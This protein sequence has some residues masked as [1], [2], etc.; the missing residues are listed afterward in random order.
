MES[1]IYS[2]IDS[3]NVISAQKNFLE[4]RASLLRSLQYLTNYKVIRKKE[5]LM[6]IKL[7]KLVKEANTEI[8]KLLKQVPKTENI[9]E[10]EIEYRNIRNKRAKIK[11]PIHANIEA[12][13]EDIQRRLQ[14]L[15]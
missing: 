3:R 7:S 13:L 15:P 6:K 1:P 11:D 8:N 12:E 5:I 10:M 4:T 9:K 2:K 14:E